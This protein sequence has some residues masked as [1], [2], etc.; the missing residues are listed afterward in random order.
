MG[1][2]MTLDKKTWPPSCTSP[3]C[4]LDAIVCKRLFCNPNFKQQ[5]FRPSLSSHLPF[6]LNGLA[7]Q[8]CSIPSCNFFCGRTELSRHVSSGGRTECCFFLQGREE[9]AVCLFLGDRD[10]VTETIYGDARGW[11]GAKGRQSKFCS[12]KGQPPSC[13][14]PRGSQALE[15]ITASVSAQH[16]VT[17]LDPSPARPSSRL[18]LMRQQEMSRLYRFTVQEKAKMGRQVAY[19]NMAVFKFLAFKNEKVCSVQNQK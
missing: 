7:C 11:G 2:I 9:R 18:S 10:V 19:D 17:T 15:R 16:H 14:K 4:V 1:W 5:W 6:P 8:L 12:K 13:H 3:T